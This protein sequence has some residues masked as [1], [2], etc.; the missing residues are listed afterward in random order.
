MHLSPV[1]GGT[2][3]RRAAVYT[4]CPSSLVSTALGQSLGLS[5]A[6]GFS[7]EEWQVGQMDLHGSTI[8]LFQLSICLLGSPCIIFSINFLFQHESPSACPASEYLLAQ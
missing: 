5:A 4:V 2:F 8:S 7:P 1:F 6:N 3:M